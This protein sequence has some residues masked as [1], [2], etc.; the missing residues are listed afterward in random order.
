MEI[1]PVINA[2]DKE[3]FLQKMGKLCEFLPEGSWVHVDAAE[4]PFATIDTYAGEEELARFK[5]YNFECHYMGTNFARAGRL[6][7]AFSCVFLHRQWWQDDSREPFLRSYAQKIGIA[8]SLH[9]A[10]H[11]VQVPEGVVRTLFLGG[12]PGKAGQRF[13]EA[14]LSR[15]SFLKSA[16]PRVTLTYDGGVSAENIAAIARAGADRAVVS[17][18]IWNSV[19]P[20][21]SYD[22]LRKKI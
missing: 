6:A 8:F 7:S 13:N 5:Q 2:A 1:I 4:R 15:I 22:E 10:P 20:R 11:D 18:A 9:D 12:V 16:Y 14:S 17:S 19:N 3:E 21:E